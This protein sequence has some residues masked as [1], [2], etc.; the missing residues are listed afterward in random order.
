MQM[1]LQF[2]I[3]DANYATYQLKL[4]AADPNQPQDGP[5]VIAVTLDQAKTKL[6]D[7]NDDS[8]M[9]IVDQVVGHLTIPDDPAPYSSGEDDWRTEFRK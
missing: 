8:L 7:L 5:E 1:Q 2:R 9:A 4:S 3:D 6:S